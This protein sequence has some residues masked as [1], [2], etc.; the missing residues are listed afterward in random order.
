MELPEFVKKIDG[1]NNFPV[2]EKILVV[3][4]YFHT[5]KGK[6]KFLASD[7]NAAFDLLHIAKPS[8]A[9]SQLTA[10]TKG[11]VKKLLGTNKGFKLNNSS[12]ENIAARL[13]KDVEPKEILF[14]LKQLE[15]KITNAQ[16]KTFL[17]EANVCFAN[18]AYR[19]A[20][21]MGWNLAYHHVCT[22]IFN[23][24]LTAFNARL[25]MQFKNEKAIVKFSDFEAIKESVVIAVA[26]ASSV[27]SQ[28]TEKTLK[29]K[30]DIRNSAAHP[31]ALVVLPVTAEEVIADLVQ[32]ILL[33][34][35]L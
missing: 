5:F 11:F 29:A 3:G 15:A 19:A 27:I 28:S 22:F 17:H 16:Q 6:E 26:K 14:Q 8:N 1:F 31:S 20:I 7:I 24:H 32:N 25:P 35:E 2:F 34:S 33:K 10:M 18:Q 4:Y 30:L 21:V 23:S 9:S 13:P 12:R